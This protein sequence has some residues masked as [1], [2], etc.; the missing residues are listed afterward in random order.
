MKSMRR[1]D[2]RK[3]EIRNKHLSSK[4]GGGKKGFDYFH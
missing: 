3:Y 4:L 1:K 2:V